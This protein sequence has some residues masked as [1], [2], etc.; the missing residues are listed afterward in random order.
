MAE[1][2]VINRFLTRNT[3]K[4]GDA[5]DYVVRADLFFDFGNDNRE[6]Q[7]DRKTKVGKGKFLKGMKTFFGTENYAVEHN[8]RHDVFFGFKTREHVS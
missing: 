4:T 6:M 2:D 7:Q 1:R 5:E 8:H 3:V